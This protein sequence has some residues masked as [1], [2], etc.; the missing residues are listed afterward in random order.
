VKIRRP[1]LL[2]AYG[3]EARAFLHSGLY[4]SLAESGAAPAIF[5]S[6]PSSGA[7]ALLAPGIVRQAPDAEESR[8]LL[9]L[10]ALSRR[11]GGQGA[12]GIAERFI[13]STTG[14][15]I[16]W[17]SALSEAGV[18]AVICASYNSARTL[19]ALQTATNLGIPTIVFENSWKDVHRN[20]YSPA[21]P[22]AVGFT[23]RVAE[24]AYL[25]VSRRPAHLDVCGSLHLSALARAWPIP[26]ADFC[27]RLG[28]DPARPIVC[29]SA[30]KAATARQEPSWMERLWRRFR[31]IEFS[32][33][34]QLLIRSNPMDQG[35]PLESVLRPNWEWSPA[36]DWCCPLAEDAATWSAAIRHSALNVSLPST[37]TM[38][39]AAF[40]RPAINPV[41]EA[42]AK[43]QFFSGS[44][45][46]ARR[47]E[48]ALPATTFGELED[49]VLALLAEPPAIIRSA[50]RVDAV[51]RAADLMGRVE[52]STQRLRT[53]S[54]TSLRASART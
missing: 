25:R 47:N 7:F 38:E 1:A 3:P 45:A 2:V 49:L 48:W 24:E 34:P 6:R 51:A 18:D 36:D 22:T 28:L 26:R 14:G 41:F 39:F 13:A 40:G 42:E 8:N 12:A 43:K 54:W 23:T 11:A 16:A 27:A 19:P 5:A 9:R 10:R 31:S 53:A 29:C 37:V 32:R 21:T 30:A 50:P 20:A 33:R 46:E 44:Y 15:T 17:K 35:E 4:E 52:A